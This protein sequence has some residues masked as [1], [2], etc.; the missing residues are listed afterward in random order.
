MTFSLL[1][2]R[3][4]F[5]TRRFLFQRYGSSSRLNSHAIFE[6][7]SNPTKTKVK[8]LSEK[9]QVCSLFVNPCLMSVMSE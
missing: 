2:F 7:I 5:L 4:E 6:R 9:Q 8:E 3:K 1:I